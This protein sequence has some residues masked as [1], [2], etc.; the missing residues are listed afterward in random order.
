MSTTPFEYHHSEHSQPPPA[1]R[2]DPRLEP[3][4]QLA[5]KK[6]N[7]ADPTTQGTGIVAMED[8][9]DA[10][11]SERAAVEQARASQCPWVDWPCCL[12]PCVWPLWWVACS[13]TCGDCGRAM[14]GHGANDAPAMAWRRGGCEGMCWYLLGCCNLRAE[15]LPGDH[16]FRNAHMAC[17]GRLCYGNLLFIE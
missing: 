10:L 4:T 11:R 1:P 3:A 9:Y 12:V 5:Q 15:C 8:A 14:G 16:C 7:K 13:C 6:L 17:C 2:Y